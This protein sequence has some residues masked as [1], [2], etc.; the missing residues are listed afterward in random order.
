MAGNAA[1]MRRASPFTFGRATPRGCP[2]VGQFPN[3]VDRRR[4]PH[5]LRAEPPDFRPQPP[6]PEQHHQMREPITS[7]RCAQ[8]RRGPWIVA[9]AEPTTQATRGGPC[10]CQ[11][12]AC[13]RALRGRRSCHRSGGAGNLCLAMN[14]EMHGAIAERKRDPLKIFHSARRPRPPNV[15]SLPREYSRIKRAPPCTAHSA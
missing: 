4:H 5:A 11:G 6:L 13:R 14:V 8:A 15:A 12:P 9:L 3:K 7:R 2:R 1:G 10:N